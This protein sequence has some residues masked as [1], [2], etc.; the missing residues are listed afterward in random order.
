MRS[1]C[2]R[3]VRSLCCVSESGRRTDE[4]LKK[5]K[6]CEL[7]AAVKLAQ[8]GWPRTATQRRNGW[9]P[10]LPQRAS[11][12][13]ERDQSVLLCLLLLLRCGSDEK[14]AHGFRRD[15]TTNASRHVFCEKLTRAPRRMSERSRNCGPVCERRICGFYRRMREGATRSASRGNRT[16]DLISRTKEGVHFLVP[17]KA[18]LQ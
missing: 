15:Q 11:R 17:R 18:C 12:G 3:Q 13:A 5:R 4:K 9:G 1:Q 14:E 7:F 8:N 6:S 10:L 2:C 16:C